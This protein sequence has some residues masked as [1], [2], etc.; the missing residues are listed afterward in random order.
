MYMALVKVKTIEVWHTLLDT[1]HDISECGLQSHRS[2]L[3][4]YMKNSRN[5]MK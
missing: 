2:K 4:D 3:K 1:M 5:Y